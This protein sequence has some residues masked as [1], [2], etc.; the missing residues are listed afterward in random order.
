MKRSAIEQFKSKSP[1]LLQTMLIKKW[2]LNRRDIRLVYYYYLINIE[3][4][5][6]YCLSS[7]SLQEKFIKF[8]FVYNQLDTI[9]E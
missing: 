7:T 1:A 6:K 2:V 3:N 5:I 9:E 4:N 8:D